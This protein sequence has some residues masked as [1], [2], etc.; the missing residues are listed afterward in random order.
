VNDILAA[1]NHYGSLRP[2]KPYPDPAQGEKPTCI[3]TYPSQLK[4][5][6]SRLQNSI[7]K[8]AL[9]IFFYVSPSITSGDFRNQVGT[10]ACGSL[11]IMD[12]VKKKN[13][14]QPPNQTTE[15]FVPDAVK[16]R[17]AAFSLSIRKSNAFFLHGV[18]SQ[19]EK[20]GTSWPTTFTPSLTKSD[21]SI[22]NHCKDGQPFKSV[23][24]LT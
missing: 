4:I 14:H 5:C 3:P 8:R 21:D 20:P 10:R 12:V 16:V 18:V 11:W 23:H 17:A 13:V 9:N 22:H 2:H 7:C 19:F 15:L 24:T 6:S 1:I